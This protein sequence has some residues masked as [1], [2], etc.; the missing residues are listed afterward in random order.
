MNQLILEICVHPWNP[1]I[2][3]IVFDGC[4]RILTVPRHIGM[5]SIKKSPGSSCY[6]FCCEVCKRENA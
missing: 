4:Y 5:A 1:K 3:G 6:V 2:V